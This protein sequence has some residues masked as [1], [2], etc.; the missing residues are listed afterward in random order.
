VN[1][2]KEKVTMSKTT[3]Q[4][5]AGGMIEKTSFRAMKVLQTS[6]APGQV[7]CRHCQGSGCKD[8]GW[9][10]TEEA[11]ES[12]ERARTMVAES[13]SRWKADEECALTEQAC[14]A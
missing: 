14:Q 7:A 9:F 2:K 5:V 4:P 11:R 3:I 8:C 10:G 1:S 12:F 13:R 6:C